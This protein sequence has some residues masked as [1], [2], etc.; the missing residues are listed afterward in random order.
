MELPFGYMSNDMNVNPLMYN[1]NKVYLKYCDGAS[2]AGNN[3]TVSQYQGH[4]LHFKGFRNLHAYFQSLTADHGLRKATDVVVGGC[5][6]GGL[7]TYLHA[8]WWHAVLP[9]SAIVVAL[10]DSGFFLDYNAPSGNPHY[11]SDMMWVFNQQNCTAGVNQRCIAAHMSSKDTYK[12]YFA[13]HTGPHI[14]TPIMPLQPEYDSWQAANIL[15]SN[16]PSPLNQYGQLL[17]KRMK[18]AILNKAQNG[19]FLD[20]CFHHCQVWGTIRNVTA[21]KNVEAWYQ[22][23]SAGVVIDGSAYPC[24]AC[25]TGKGEVGCHG[26]SSS[27]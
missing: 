11:S 26:D 2:F 20:S 23:T 17:T 5:S 4:P 25:C 12:C 24:S 3:A 9:S 18:N 15:G 14:V 1:W 19:V 22:K 7:A 27:E 16:D 10:P 6:A 21:G 13:E 8:D